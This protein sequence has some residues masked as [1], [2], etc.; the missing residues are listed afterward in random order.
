MARPTPSGNRQQ[1][2]TLL[3][4]LFLIAGF[5]VA[6]AALGTLW[7]VLAQRDKEA[8]LLFVGD[9]YR[10]AIES[11]FLA[12]PG[13]DK[14]Y[15]PDLETLLRD[16]RFP[17][18]VRHLRRLYPDPFSGSLE[19]GLLREPRGGI[20]GIFSTAPGTPYKMVGFPVLYESFDG[21]TEYRGWVFA[22]PV[23]QAPK[24][25]GEPIFD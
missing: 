24:L 10:R 8:E 7:G 18:T 19:W 25:S 20:I 22:A 13:K 14:R 4:L 6:L 15:P 17:A 5:G 11:Y 3:V 2:F 23:E 12:T 16:P 9:Q 21:A 1:G